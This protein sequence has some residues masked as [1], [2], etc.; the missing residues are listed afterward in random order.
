M[1]PAYVSGVFLF[2][3]PAPKP[4]SS[5]LSVPSL[6]FPLDAP[7]PQ[8]LPFSKAGA[9]ATSLSRPSRTE[10]GN[11]IAALCEDQIELMQ[12]IQQIN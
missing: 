6:P 3:I 10:Q 9:F 7:H 2:V 4:G 11:R 5:L 12:M 8:Q 1:P